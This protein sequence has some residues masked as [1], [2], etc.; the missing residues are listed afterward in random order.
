MQTLNGSL[1][2][3]EVA[4]VVL[5][6]GEYLSCDSVIY[7]IGVE[8]NLDL[9]KTTAIETNRGII[10]DEQMKTSVDDVYAAGDVTECNGEVEGLWTR[11]L[12][13]GKVAGA[14]MAASNSVYKKTLPVTIF[15]AFDVALF[16][17]GLVDEKQCDV[18]ISEEEDGIY[19]R[20]FIK[21]KK[22]VGVIS[23]EG[24][25]ASIP[26]KTAIEQEVSLEGLDLE[27]ISLSQLMNEVKERQAVLV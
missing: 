26:Y 24:V 6:E 2:D 17:I 10:V 11:A 5:N 19:T 14:N 3:D 7:S 12:E 25:A 21:D 13:Q 9:I 4:E 23:L 1:G 27:H 18:S 8:P 16:S 22:I 15:N 20:V